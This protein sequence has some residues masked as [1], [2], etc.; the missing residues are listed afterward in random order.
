MGTFWGNGS[1]HDRTVVMVASES[2]LT[3]QSEWKHL[4]VGKLYPNKESFKKWCW[5][6]YYKRTDV[7]TVSVLLVAFS[8]LQRLYVHVLSW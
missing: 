7:L 5:D 1:V 4:M 3:T 6:L 8:L 2:H